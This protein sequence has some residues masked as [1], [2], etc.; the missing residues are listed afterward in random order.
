MSQVAGGIKQFASLAFIGSSAIM[1]GVNQSP[2]QN[3]WPFNPNFPG[4]FSFPAFGTVE[5]LTEI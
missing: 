2:R 1:A 4:A 5:W 3:D